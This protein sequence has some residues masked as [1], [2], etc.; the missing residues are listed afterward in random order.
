M[1]LELRPE[2]ISGEKGNGLEIGVPGFN[3]SPAD[4][5]D[6]P[7]QVYIEFY[8]GKLAVHVWDGSGEDPQTIRIEP[9]T[10]RH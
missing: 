6:H 5:E 3:S 7:S 2:Q 9:T 8:E 1:R 10:N 4:A